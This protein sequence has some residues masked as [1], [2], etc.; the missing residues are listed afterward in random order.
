MAS[1]DKI[2]DD[3]WKITPDGK[4]NWVDYYGLQGLEFEKKI[5]TFYS[6]FHLGWL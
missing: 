3:S 6:Q 4:I 1:E 5:V 2:F